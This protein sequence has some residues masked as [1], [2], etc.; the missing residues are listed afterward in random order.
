MVGQRTRNTLLLIVCLAVTFIAVGAGGL[1]M[2]A[3]PD[4]T[5]FRSLAK[6][7]W[8]PP[9]WLFGPVW[10][11]LYITMAVSL[12]LVLVRFPLSRM[13]GCIAIYAVQ[14]F[15]NAIW[16]GLFFGRQNPLAGLIDIVLLWIV[17]SIMLVY[18]ARLRLLAGLL[19]I[20][21][22]GWLTFAMALN[23]QIW[24]MN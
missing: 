19:L 24:R 20:P 14:M 18:F 9:G 2:G 1:L 23:F 6:P 7:S 10:T 15:L 13:K 5:W 16:T 21:Y 3:G 22:W 8:M 4:K 11:L 12:W 17:L